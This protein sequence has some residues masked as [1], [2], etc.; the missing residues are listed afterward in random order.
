MRCSSFR[1]RADSVA[2]VSPSI[3]G[4]TACSTTG[5][6]SHPESTK[7]TVQ[8]EKRTPDSSACRCAWRPGVAQPL[9]QLPVVGLPV[10]DALRGEELGGDAGAAGALQGAGAGDVAEHHR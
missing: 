6:V 8:P 9:P 4:T 5:P 1:M 3:A 7:W 2:S 10:G